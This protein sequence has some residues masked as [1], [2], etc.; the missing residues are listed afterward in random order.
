M[1]FP[2][3]LPCTRVDTAKPSRAMMMADVQS[4]PSFLL[5]EDFPLLTVKLGIVHKTGTLKISFFYGFHFVFFDVIKILL[6][7]HKKGNIFT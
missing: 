4:N 6:F 3:T 5:R 2:Y 7:T 1:G